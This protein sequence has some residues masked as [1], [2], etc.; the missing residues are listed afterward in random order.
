MTRVFE[1][2]GARSTKLGDLLLRGHA[3]LTGPEGRRL[4]SLLNAHQLTITTG[5]QV[6]D[7]V[8]TQVVKEHSELIY[9]KGGSSLV[10]PHPTATSSLMGNYNTALQDRQ[11]KL[12][13]VANAQENL[14]NIV[15]DAYGITS[16]DWRAVVA[17]GV[18][19][20]TG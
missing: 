4:G 5:D 19:W 15:L 14:D 2:H 16:P 7:D 17:A 1:S 12:V 9:A 6:A 3:V 11:R 13:A 8:I 10:V 20:A 18:P